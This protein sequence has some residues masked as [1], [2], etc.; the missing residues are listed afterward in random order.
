MRQLHSQRGMVAHIAIHLPALEIFLPIDCSV[1]KV[2][3]RAR[4]F[5]SSMRAQSLVSQEAFS[6]EA[7]DMTIAQSHS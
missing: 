4:N 5:L 1:E 3:G 7:S 6:Q 2:P